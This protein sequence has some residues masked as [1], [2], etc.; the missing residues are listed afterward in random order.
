MHSKKVIIYCRSID[1]VSEVF[2]TF[3]SC[4]GRYAYVD[5]I[6]DANQLLIEM[7]HKSTHPDSKG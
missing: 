4:L 5:G 6:L 3:K 2:L 1:T 7:F